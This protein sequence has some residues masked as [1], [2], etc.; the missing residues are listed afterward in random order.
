MFLSLE[1]AKKVDPSVEQWQIDALEQTVRGMTNNH[2]HVDA[3]KR[4]FVGSSG[5]L[6]FRDNDVVL[7]S[8]NGVPLASS[9]DFI[10]YLH[11]GDTLEVY[12][13]GVNDGVFEIESLE[14][15]IDESDPAAS[16]YVIK[17]RLP[18]DFAFVE[19]DF[20]GS[21]V[22]V[23]YPADI[24]SGMLRLISYDKTMSDKIGVK[25]ET[26][27]RLSVTYFDQLGTDTTEGYPTAYMSFLIKYRRMKWN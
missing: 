22:K 24:A 1:K 14:P 11:V 13:T 6:F 7:P 9:T 18:E 25:Q 16:E 19:G 4:H 26:V 2:F 17:V 3:T 5:S 20:G 10:R 8:F 12:G 27:S 23:H 21:L 15:V